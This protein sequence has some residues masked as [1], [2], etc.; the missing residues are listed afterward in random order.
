M[1][2]VIACTHPGTGTV[3]LLR[4]LSSGRQAL[5]GWMHLQ[6]NYARPDPA[7][8]QIWCKGGQNVA[9]KSGGSGMQKKK[10]KKAEKC[11]N[12]LTGFW[13]VWSPPDRYH[14]THALKKMKLFLLFNDFLIMT[15]VI[16]RR[17]LF[18]RVEGPNF[19]AWLLESVQPGE[20]LVLIFASSWAVY[21]SLIK[22]Q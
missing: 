17:G 15:L 19:S 8:L 7:V 9:L 4:T 3:N 12:I 18:S 2:P 14:S 5:L 11:T 13:V 21:K 22:I 6:R 20:I 16:S 1:V 10:K